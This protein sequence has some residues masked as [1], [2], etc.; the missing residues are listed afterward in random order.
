VVKALSIDPEDRTVGQLL[1]EY[2]GILDE[3]RRREIVRTTN[4]PLSDYAELLFCSAFNWT[5]ASKSSSGH[6]ATDTQGVRYQIKGRRLAPLNAS[7]QMSAIRNLEKTPFDHLAGLLVDKSLRVIRA[8]I[9]PIDI[10]RAQSKHQAHT[11]SW[12]FLLRDEIWNLS[13]VR[14][15]THELTAAAAAI[16][17]RKVPRLQIL[18]AAS[19]LEEKRPQVQSSRS[20]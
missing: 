17:D 15:V 11:N 7:R 6:D 9:V 1:A 18:T 2:G 20:D 4:N 16:D 19:T 14:D 3:L 8:A 10:V 12:R 13:G 5:R